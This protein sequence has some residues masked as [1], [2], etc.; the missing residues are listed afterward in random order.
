MDTSFPNIL[1]NLYLYV[2]S[3]K[4]KNKAPAPV[5]ITAEQLLREAK[6]RQ[7]ELVPAV[8][9]NNSL[10]VIYSVPDNFQSQ[11]ESMKGFERSIGVILSKSSYV[12]HLFC[13]V[14][15]PA[16]STSLLS[17]TLTCNFCKFSYYTKDLSFL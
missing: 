2:L 4:V 7:L 15:E 10:S 17:G 16:F 9:T 6:E 1:I 8:C 5:Q 13:R 12:H 14:R 3:F 11:E